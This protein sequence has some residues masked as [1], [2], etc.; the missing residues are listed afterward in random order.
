MSIT[1]YDQL[2]SGLTSSSQILGINKTSIS[3]QGTGGFTSLWRATGVPAQGAIPGTSSGTCTDDLTGGFL[4]TNPSTGKNTY[5]GG[6]SIAG[7]VSHQMIIYDRLGHMGGLNGTTTTAQTVNLTIPPNRLANSDGT[8]VDWWLEIYTDIGTTAVSATVTYTDQTDTSRTVTIGLGGTSPINQDSR[9][10]QIIPNAGQ[11]IKSIQTIQHATTA[12]AGS[13]GITCARRL[14]QVNMGLANIG[15]N[16]D[17]AQ[18]GMPEISDNA[19]MWMVILS[20]TTSS[21]QISGYMN[22]IQG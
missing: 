4:F 19:C 2:I 22:L 6:L 20:S 17:F 18:L 21:G 14:T 10:Y 8:N 13:Y 1:S 9:C 12:T 5:L 11:Y 7:S 16:Y 3:T 15:L